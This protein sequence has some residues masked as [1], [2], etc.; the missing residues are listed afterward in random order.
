[1]TTITI[2]R[3][4][5]EQAL[6]LIEGEYQSL[7]EDKAYKVLTD[8]RAALAAPASAPC[9][10][11]PMSPAP[12]GEGSCPRPSS[13]NPSLWTSAWSARFPPH[14]NGSWTPKKASRVGLNP[15]PMPWPGALASVALPGRLRSSSEGRCCGKEMGNPR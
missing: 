10:A 9:G 12:G 4:V 6:D 3:S 11:G 7:P 8:L 14:G 15:S 5:L 1:M 2:E 13:R